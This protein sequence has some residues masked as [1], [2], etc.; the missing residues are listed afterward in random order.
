MR[1]RPSIASIEKK[2]QKYEL[3]SAILAMWIEVNEIEDEKVR[4]KLVSILLRVL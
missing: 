2:N 1:W 4:Q 3:A